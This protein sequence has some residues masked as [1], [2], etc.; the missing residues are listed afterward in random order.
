[1]PNLLFSP[2]ETNIETRV[3]N[4]GNVVF[5]SDTQLARIEQYVEEALNASTSDLEAALITPILPGNVSE[6]NWASLTNSP[7][8]YE[9]ENDANASP[10]FGKLPEPIL[11]PRGNITRTESSVRQF[12]IA[13]KEACVV[14]KNIVRKLQPPIKEGC[15][16]SKLLAPLVSRSKTT[17]LK[18]IGKICSDSESGSDEN[19]SSIKPMRK[20]RILNSDESYSTKIETTPIAPRRNARRKSTMPQNYKR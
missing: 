11:I 6:T 7:G 20:K 2:V 13:R 19:I 18:R 15:E 10:V 4:S 3:K 1:M 5:S 8:E 14:N 12:K 17:F 9:L 16:K